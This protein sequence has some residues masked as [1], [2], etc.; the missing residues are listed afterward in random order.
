MAGGVKLGPAGILMMLV[1]GVA[2]PGLLRS[3]AGSVAATPAARVTGIVYD[4]MAMRPLNGAVVQLALVP[5]PR[6]I[7]A[8]R[9]I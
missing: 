2:S 1:I 4:S 3:Q 9:S 8:V 5:A 7:S 6:T